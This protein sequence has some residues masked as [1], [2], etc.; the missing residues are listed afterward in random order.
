MVLRIAYVVD[1]RM[2]TEKANGYQSAQMCQA[3]IEEGCDLTLISPSRKKIVREGIQTT[4]TVEDYY[5]LRVNLAKCRL[6]SLDFIHLLQE[7]MGLAD[8]NILSKAGSMVT[9]YSMSVSLWVH[10]LR[11]GY[12]VIYIRSVHTLIA[13]LA[14]MPRSQWQKV[15]F[16]VHTLPQRPATLK[17]LLKSLPHIG[18]I[19]T[20]TGHLKRE[21]AEKGIPPEAVCVAHDAVDLQTFGIDTGKAEARAQLGLPAGAT[22]AS[23]VGKFNTN[24]SE[25]GIPEILQSAKHILPDHPDLLFY[26]VG[27]PLEQVAAYRGLIGECG[28]PQENFIFMDKQSI[29]LVPLFLKASDV[30]LMPHPWT[31][32]YAY[33]VSP[34]KLFEYM[35]SGRPIVA[36]DLPSIREILRHGE[37]ALLGAPGD[38][39]AIAGN[40]RAVMGDTALADRI[41]ARAREDV[42]EFTWGR[43]CAR[44]LEFVAERRK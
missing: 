22:I 21:L 11:H 23:F 6:P 3:F 37:N 9:S 7:R 31:T 41:A 18:G 26:F 30:L 13:L 38:P 24:G 29:S 39:R 15:F 27:G 8:G 34:L 25:K 12:D 5:K 1:G 19:V 42:R 28:L 44:I 10:L 20:V 40:I 33:H 32:F 2:P 36:S 43:R 14:L 17:R 4:T 16:E 35:S